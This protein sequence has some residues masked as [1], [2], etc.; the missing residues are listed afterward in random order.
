MGAARKK[1]VSKGTRSM[2]NNKTKLLLTI[3]AAIALLVLSAVAAQASSITIPGLNGH[4]ANGNEN[5]VVDD[6]RIDDSGVRI[7][8]GGDSV[9][10]LLTGQDGKDGKDGAGGLVVIRPEDENTA[11]DDDTDT[12][13]DPWQTGALHYKDASL[14]P[15]EA[16]RNFL[17]AIDSDKNGSISPEEAAAYFEKNDGCLDLMN[18]NDTVYD[19]TGV[20]CFAAWL[21]GLRCKPT[22]SVPLKLDVSGL[23]LLEE[24]VCSDCALTGLDL[25]QNPALRVLECG[26][27]PMET[28]DISACPLLVDAAKNGAAFF[29]I[30]NEMLVDFT[31]TDAAAYDEPEKLTVTYLLDNGDVKLSVPYTTRLIL[32][33]VTIMFTTENDDMQTVKAEKGAPFALP[34]CAFAVPGGKQFAGWKIGKTVYQPGDEITPTGNI[35]AVAVWE[36]ISAPAVPQNVT[37]K[38]TAADTLTVSWD[39]V[40]GATQYNVYRYNG[41]KKAYVYKGTTYAAAEKPTQY[42]DTGLNAGTNYHYK[43]VAV[44]KSAD[45]TLVSAKSA[46]ACAKAI[47]TP[48]VPTNVTVTATGEK[49][50]TVTW[51]AV[52][53]ATQYNVY[54]YNGAKKTY[55]YKGTTFAAAE[56]PTAYVDEGLS[57]GTAYYYKVVAVTKAEGLTL[58]SDKSASANAKALGTPAVPT[59]VKAVSNEAKTVTV[60]WSAVKGATQ[61]NVYR[62][63][64]AK[65]TYVY[66]GT[67]Y[68]EAEQ[69]TQYTATGLNTGTTYHFKVTAACKGSGLTFVSDKSADA[70]AKAN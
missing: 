19:Y 42:V 29:S 22:G 38:A 43:V 23:P 64:G 63:N 69:P 53:G 57:V 67:T 5:I 48:A 58:V 40:E 15:D 7:L 68:A 17:D 25:S 34:N 59:N 50:L 10:V 47:G 8:P 31:E 65:K 37:V 61:Y 24:L 44:K 55:V 28:L 16:F 33:T 36:D 32:E 18:A 3:L 30:G 12:P 13:A 70:G 21:T 39:A 1:T 56:A 45:Y 9:G 62:Y 27:D 6:N 49:Q 52:S 20:E 60:T 11:A 41:T 46:D 26:N 51:K 35:I 2:K 4:G 54:R 14:F 66:V